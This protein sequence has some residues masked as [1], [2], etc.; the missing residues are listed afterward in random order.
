MSAEDSNG[1][2][3]SC[4]LQYVEFDPVDHAQLCPFYTSLLT[5]SGDESIAFEELDLLTSDLE[6]LLAA[7]N[8][9][10]RLLEGETKVLVDWAEKK[11]KK[12]V[13]QK[14]L[15]ILNSLTYKRSKTLTDDRGSKKQKLDDSKTSSQ[16]QGR[17]KGLGKEV[18]V[19]DDSY[20]VTSKTKAD[21]PNRFWAAVEPYCTDLSLED[22]KFLE[23][24][25][26][27]GDNEEEY[28]KIPALG[29][30]YSE[31]WAQE[32]LIE[33]Q[34]EGM[35][36]SE[37]RR[38]ALSNSSENN[39]SDQI[40]AILKKSENPSLQTEEDTCPFGPLTQR[41]VS[42]LI[43][44]NII[45]PMDQSIVSNLKSGESAATR[46]GGSTSR[47]PVKAPH[48]PHTRT[49]EARIREELIFQGLIDDDHGE[50]EDDEVLSELRKHQS[51]LKTLV[52]KNKQAKQDLLKLVH[53]EMRRQELRHRCR[54]V[55]ADIMENFRKVSGCKQKKKSPTK[56]EKETAWKAL[57][58]RE[59][60]YRLLDNK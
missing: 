22:V 15:E 45:A 46:S 10:M 12:M 43:E 47:T 40:S 29:K 31:K 56:K 20:S 9:R 3:D 57:R 30:H 44:E 32:D 26:K 54:L 55:D 6:T 50:E 27:T 8:R 36:L 60:I 16:S 13:R 37:K 28:S 33:E 5:R 34:L 1:E 14:E 24:S 41:L 38:G 59:A 52:S 51:E 25:I 42:A 58:E 23:D 35:K 53:E 4:P 49:L 2:K 19:D 11:D 39:K 48:V 18:G 21:A 7:C 17:K